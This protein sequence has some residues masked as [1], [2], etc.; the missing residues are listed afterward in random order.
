MSL[1]NR[2]SNTPNGHSNNSLAHNL[3]NTSLWDL[4]ELRILSGLGQ[5]DIRQGSL[6]MKTLQLCSKIEI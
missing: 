2:G 6:C 3:C 4:R 1:A 5:I